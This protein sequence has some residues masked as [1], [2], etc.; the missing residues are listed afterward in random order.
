MDDAALAQHQARGQR[1]AY[2]MLAMASPRGRAVEPAPGVQASV[3]PERPGRSILNA[4]VYDDPGV[5]LAGYD[6]LAAVYAAAGVYAW[7]V[8]AP[9]GDDATGRALAGR[10]HTLDGTPMRMAAAIDDLDLEPRMELDLAPGDGWPALAR[11]NDAAYGLPPGEGFAGALDGVTHPGARAYV[12]L[13]AG[14]PVAA[15]GMLVEDGGCEVV[16]VATVP[17]AQG[18]GLGAELMRHG[19][20]QARA[21]GAVT[22]G[23]E[24]SSRGEGVY[25][26]LG[27]RRLGR[28]GLWELRQA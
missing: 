12:A 18:R 8:W 23:L 27:Y 28:F 20:R 6:E 13:E 21:A 16:F 19:L 5:L 14:D 10:G 26:R 11:C 9:P 15:A 2:R 7:T 3:V 25:A 17:R 1:A 22:T 4:V 24:S